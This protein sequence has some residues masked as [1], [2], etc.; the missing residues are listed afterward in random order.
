MS[1]SLQPH[2][3][4]CLWNSPGQNTRVG[5]LS[6]YQG[7]FLSQELNCGLLHYRWILYQLSYQGSLMVQFRLS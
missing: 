6:H 2:E 3:L 1:D 7:I 5:N 4:Y